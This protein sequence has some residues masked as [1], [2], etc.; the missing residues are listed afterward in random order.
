M[1]MYVCVPA[2]SLTFTLS[3]QARTQPSMTSC[4]RVYKCIYIFGFPDNVVRHT[5]AFHQFA[6]TC[7]FY[8][9]SQTMGISL[10][11]FTTQQALLEDSKLCVSIKVHTLAYIGIHGEVVVVVVA[12]KE[13]SIAFEIETEKDERE[14]ESEREK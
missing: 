6:S 13:F 8:I 4:L 12:K 2:L 3:L 7:S 1:K 11:T 9:H 14:R 5:V 10:P